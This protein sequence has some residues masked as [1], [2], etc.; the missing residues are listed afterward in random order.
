MS[1]SSLEKDVAEVLIDEAT[2]QAKVAELGARISADYA[3][4]QVTLVS[5][6]KGALPFMADLMRAITSPVRIDLME[7]SS[8][9][10]STE[11]SGRVRILKDLSSSI[12]GEHVLIVEDIIDTGLTLNYLTQYLSGKEPASLSICTLL[13]KP[14]RRL[15]DIDLTYC[16]FEIPDRFVIG[17]GLDYDEIYRNLPYIGVLKPEVYGGA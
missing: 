1:A 12:Q 14:A 5:V 2:L 9:G 4:R 3:D 6:L 13:D 15:V 10:G 7:V 8:Y 11:T 16:G 17:Y